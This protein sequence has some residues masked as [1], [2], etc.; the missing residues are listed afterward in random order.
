MLFFVDHPF[1]NQCW[2]SSGNSFECN[3]C[4]DDFG[5]L[6]VSLPRCQDTQE[7]KVLNVAGM[8]DKHQL[9]NKKLSQLCCKSDLVNNLRT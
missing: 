2:H 9:G 3:Y 4:E 6:I 7:G 5:K 1:V 8:D